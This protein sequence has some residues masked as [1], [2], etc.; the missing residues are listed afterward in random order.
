MERWR[1]NGTNLPGRL[2]SW[3]EILAA[4]HLTFEIS[5]TDRTPA[6]F[7]GGVTRRTIGYL[8]LVDCASSPW[9]G[10]RGAAEIEARG[11][12]AHEDVLGFQ[13]VCRG[14]ELVREGRREMTLTPGQ[15]VMWD[16]LMPT[17][18]EIVKPFY[19]R[20]LLFPRERVLAVCP[21]LADLRSV[22]PVDRSASAR[23]LVRYMHAMAAESLQLEPSAAAVAADTALELLRAAIEPGLPT[24]RAAEREAMRAEVRRYIRNHLQDRDLGPA[25]IAQAFAMSVRALHGLFEDGDLSVAVLVR[26][27]RLA[28]CLED[29]RRVNGG[30][31]AAIAFRWGFREPAHFSRVF[32]RHYGMTPTEVRHGALV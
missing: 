15:I 19:K 22:P 10:H 32:K 7:A 24:G 9:R 5:A 12:D 21:R 26:N 3:S 17:D 28:R 14:V 6:A 31:V 4:T 2:D 23:L 13:F 25:S 20:T 30:S 11:S 18:L 16:A 29:L 1:V 8:D 27:E